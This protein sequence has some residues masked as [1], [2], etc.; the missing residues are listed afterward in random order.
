MIQACSPQSRLA[1][2]IG[3]SGLIAGTTL[4]TKTMDNIKKN[5][6]T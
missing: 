1:A 4:L 6:L 5:K 3:L 2:T